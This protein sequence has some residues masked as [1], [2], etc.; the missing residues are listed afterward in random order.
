MITDK[1]HIIN[2][3]EFIDWAKEQINNLRL[4]FSIQE[5]D[6]GQGLQKAKNELEIVLR[7]ENVNK[8]LFTYRFIMRELLLNEISDQTSIIYYPDKT[9][10]ELVNIYSTVLEK[11]VAFEE[12]SDHVLITCILDTGIIKYLCKLY[13]EPY[14]TDNSL[15][16]IK[17]V[18]E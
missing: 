17:R 14:W 5:P 1:T 9:N 7:E 18:E 2:A 16:L 6:I 4:T 8:E 11:I 10:Y 13:Y 12:Y 3:I 15:Y